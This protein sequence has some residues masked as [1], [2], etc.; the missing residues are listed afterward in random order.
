MKEDKPIIFSTMP[1]R[2]LL[3]RQRVE[4]KKCDLKPYM[5]EFPFVYSL[6]KSCCMQLK[7]Q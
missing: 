7:K 6:R 1:T 2:L 5:G 3:L 4:G